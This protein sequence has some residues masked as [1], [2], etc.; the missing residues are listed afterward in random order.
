MKIA[1]DNCYVFPD[2][3]VTSRKGSGP[4]FPLAWCGL[5]VTAIISR[6]LDD[7]PNATL[8]AREM[9][10]GLN[11]KRLG[12]TRFGRKNIFSIAIDLTYHI[13][14]FLSGLWNLRRGDIYV[15][16]TDPPLLSVTTA[17]S[18]CWRRGIRSEMSE[19]AIER[20]ADFIVKRC[21]KSLLAALSVFPGQRRSSTDCAA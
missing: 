7:H 17:L 13:S 15:V 20:S 1:F 6:M 16:C 12:A 3:S 2:Q 19:K 8:P 5:K 11:I 10:A 4:A 14:A 9:V 21:R 18:I